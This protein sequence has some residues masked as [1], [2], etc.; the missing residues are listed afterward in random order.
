MY[1]PILLQISE[2]LYH[3]I[4]HFNRLDMTDVC[5]QFIVSR[6]HLCFIC[7]RKGEASA[8]AKHQVPCWGSSMWQAEVQKPPN[9]STWVH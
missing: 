3:S 4:V 9:W 7:Q 2:L 8:T 5:P 6:A 1:S